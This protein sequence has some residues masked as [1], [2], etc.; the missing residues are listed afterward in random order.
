MVVVSIV[1]VN[2]NGRK[3]LA[4]CLKSLFNQTYKDFNVILVDNNSTDDSVN[5]VKGNFPQ[6][7][8]IEC[9]KNYG[10]AEGNNIGIREAMQNAETK[11]IM[12]INNDTIIDNKY[13]ETLVSFMESS[14]KA[15]SSVGKILMIDDKRRIDSAG[16]FI[17]RKNY[18]IVNR[19]K[20]EIDK[21]QYN[22]IEEVIST[23]SAGAIYRR[24]MLSEIKIDNE[25]FD[26]DFF[27]YNE[28]VDIALRARLMGWE[29]FYLPTAVMYHH[30]AATIS[31]ISL[32]YREYLSRRN[33]LYVVLKNLSINQ[34]LKFLIKY[35]FPLNKR[36]FSPL[37]DSRSKLINSDNEIYSNKYDLSRSMVWAAHLKAIFSTIW[38][39]PRIWRKRIIIQKRKR[40]SN[41]KINV[42]INKFI[43]N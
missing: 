36:Y 5:F 23:C 34:L 24:K 28:D 1:I 39:L 6:V 12:T 4:A 20:F 32:G 26:R 9:R 18:K 15:G 38:F 7:K 27:A 8:V 21:G 33:R 42:L 35:I 22:K 13:L 2:W 37:D 10:F 3:Y 17:L 41:S 19:G 43:I 29:F 16:D 14:P 30:G 11:Y 40:I 25:Y 31:K